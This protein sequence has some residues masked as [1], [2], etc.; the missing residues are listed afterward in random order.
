M[1]DVA[2]R[3][4]WWNPYRW[5]LWSSA[6]SYYKAVR[7]FGKDAFIFR[8]DHEVV[9]LALILAEETERQK[10]GCDRCPPIEAA[11]VLRGSWAKRPV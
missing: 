2:R 6:W 10:G 5:F 9:T 3:Y 8:E 4:G 7:Q 1:L 11:M